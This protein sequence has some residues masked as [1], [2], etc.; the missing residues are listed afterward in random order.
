MA[1]EER[2]REIIEFATTDAYGEYE[3]MSGWAVVLEDAVALPFQST[4]LGRP[5]TVLEFDSDP[6]R[7]IRCAIQGEGIGRR[8]VG[9]T[10]WTGSRCRKAF[11]RCSR[12][13]TRGPWVST[14]SR[15]VSLGILRL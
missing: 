10:R 2:I 12:H 1:S 15:I 5:I 3:P 6:Q 14:D 8:W 9:G 4:A 13:S 11:G 7:G